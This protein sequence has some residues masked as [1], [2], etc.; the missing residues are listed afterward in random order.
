M[1]TTVDTLSSAELI[2]E[3]GNLSK[4][5]T[6]MDGQLTSTNGQGVDV[7]EMVAWRLRGKQPPTRSPETLGYSATT[8]DEIGCDAD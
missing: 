2:F 5:G 3:E 7:S 8:A 4:W 6:S 1:G